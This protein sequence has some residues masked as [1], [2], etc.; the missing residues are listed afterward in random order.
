MPGVT[1]VLIQTSLGRLQRQKHCLC[2]E[3]DFFVSKRKLI[4]AARIAMLS[5]TLVT[6]KN[7]LVFWVQHSFVW[8]IENLRC[9]CDWALH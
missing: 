9:C 2:T 8:R 7:V 4:V 3:S 5:C 1:Q 6:G